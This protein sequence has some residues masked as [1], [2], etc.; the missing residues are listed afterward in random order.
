M[1]KLLAILVL[2]LLLTSCSESQKSEN[3]ENIKIKELGDKMKKNYLLLTID[4][5]FSSFYN[6]AW[7]ILKQKKIPFII[8]IKL[9]KCS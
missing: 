9:L 6:N 4:D 3:Q 7:P 8:F 5:G 1:K 2:G